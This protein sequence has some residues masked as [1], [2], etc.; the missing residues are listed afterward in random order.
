MKR[1][2]DE[3]AAADKA[4]LVAG[5]LGVAKKGA[6]AREGDCEVMHSVS[7]LGSVSTRMLI[8]LSR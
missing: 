1:I 3:K 4:K 5:P 8:L 6:Q 2:A 7:A